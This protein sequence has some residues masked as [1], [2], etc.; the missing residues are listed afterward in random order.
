MTERILII[1]LKKE[2]NTYD[3]YEI[4]N[5]TDKFPKD[6]LIKRVNEYN[7]DTSK[8]LNAKIY[9]DEILLHFVEDSLQSFKYRDLV[10]SLK[11]ICEDLSSF[12]GAIEELLEEKK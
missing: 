5:C 7:N 6:D 11:S 3:H 1:Y 12:Q 10:N 9:D 4:Y 2:T 8:E